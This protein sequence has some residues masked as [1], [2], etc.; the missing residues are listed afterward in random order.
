MGDWGEELKRSRFERKF[1]S[2]YD[3]Y[4][5]ESKEEDISV[6]IR[7]D[8]SERL[9]VIDSEIAKSIL[10][11]ADVVTEADF[12]RMR[13]ETKSRYRPYDLMFHAHEDPYYFTTF[14]ERGHIQQMKI[15]KVVRLMFGDR[16]PASETGQ[17]SRAGLLAAADGVNP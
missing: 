1:V 10:D 7:R 17:A 12:N 15:S 6:C 13:R 9:E 2:G 16:F 4:L 14:N 8:M 11:M 5:R 3:Q